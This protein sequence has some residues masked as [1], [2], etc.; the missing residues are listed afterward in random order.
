MSSLT[1]THRQDGPPHG[2]GRRAEPLVLGPR[3]GTAP[4]AHASHVY[5][6]A[7]ERHPR[8]RLK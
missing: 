3:G 1:V 7:R 2:R 5:S 4:P 8:T 6:V